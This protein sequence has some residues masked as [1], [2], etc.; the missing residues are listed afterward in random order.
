MI[1]R[2]N[3]S[4]DLTQYNGLFYAIGLSISLLLVV[5]A[6]EWKFYDDGS[7]ANIDTD[8]NSMFD[9]V[10]DIPPT[11]QPP[12]PPPSKN[13]FIEIVEVPDLEEIEEDINIELDVDVTEDMVI[14][15]VEI[16]APDIMEEEAEEIFTVVENQ[17]EPLGGYE[18]FYKFVGEELKY[19]TFALRSNVEGRVFV[20][21]VV[22][23]DGTLT[24]FIVARGI[25]AGCD[26]EAV[27][28][29][30]MA[31]KWKPGKQRGRAVRVRMILPI[32]FKI[33]GQG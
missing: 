32:T 20:Q 33:A 13:R 28:V 14:E 8:I 27:R 30:K 26:Q 5:T 18:A 29:L 19:P 24:D 23:K 6:F 10:L 12:P 4:A 2:K 11:E 9:E 25:G 15:Q 31:P 21:F 7:V 17:P 1:V 16:E 22:E 3:P